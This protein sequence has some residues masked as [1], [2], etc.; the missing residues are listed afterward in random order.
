[1]T[2]MREPVRP[3]FT[4]ALLW[5]G[6]LCTVLLGFSAAANAAVY[7]AESGTLTGGAAVQ[8]D[9]TGYTGT[10]FAGGFTD[11]N[12]GNAQ[13]AWT[14]SAASAGSYTLGL[15][16]ANGTG[17]ARTLSLYVNGTK[18][19][20]TT[21]NATANWDSWSTQND[22]VTLNAG[23]NT[24]AYKY[25]TTDNGNVN[26][27]SLTT[28]AATTP[29]DLVVTSVTWTPAA[30]QTGNAMAFTAIIKNQG[31]TAT[32]AIKHGVNFLVD[33]AQVAWSDNSTS[34]LAPGA[35][36]TL[37][38]N[39]GPAGAT[40][41]ATS[42]A[43]TV[44]AYVDDQNL[45]AESDE[46]NNTLSAPFTVTAPSGG[47]DLV[48]TSLSWSPANPTAPGPVTFTAV[49]K[50]QG[51]VTKAAGTKIGVSFTVDGIQANWSDS[52]TSS[53]AAGASVTL[54]ANSGPAG[55]AS[56]A[57]TGGSHTVQAQVDD[58]N[59]ITESNESNNTSSA[60]LT[61]AAAPA[62]TNG[63][64]RIRNYW[65]SAQYLYEANGK[66]MY[67]TPAANDTSS[68]WALVD[69][70]GHKALWN[71][72]TGN[73]V[74][75]SGI[76]TSA[77]P[78]TTTYADPAPSNV[79]FDLPAAVTSG[80]NNL[81]S[82][83]T[84]AWYANIEGLK[85]FAQAY[86]IDKTWGSAQ[87]AFEQVGSVPVR[88]AAKPDLVVTG[89][90]WS[91]AVPA[92]GQAVTFSATIKN[93]GP[94]ATPAGTINK[95]S[96]AVNGTAVTAVS[97]YS[98]SLAP[99]ASVTLAQDTGSWAMSGAAPTVTATVDSNAAIAETD[100]TNNAFS[101]ILSTT[102]YGASMPY[103]T[104]EAEAGTYAGTLISGGRAW[105][106]LSS[107]ASGRAAVQLRTAGQYVQ[108]T[109]TAAGQ[110]LVVRYSIP[111]SSN[112]AA[113]DAG[114]SLYVNG[115][116]KNDLVLTNKY[117]WLY[118]T[119]S[120]EGGNKR[121][122]N[123]PNATPTNPHRFFDEVAVVLDA[124]YP[125]G[126]VIK[127]VRETS[128]QNFASTASVTVDF[129]ELEPVPAQQAM[130]SNFVS[131]TAYGGV[132]NDGIDDT[133]AMNSAIAA[134]TSSGGAKVGVWIPAGTFNFDTGTVGPGWNGT[135]TRIYL[136]AGVSLR[137]TGI[138]T[139]TLQGAFAG[140][141]AKGGNSNLSDLK[142]SATDI[143][144]DDDN[145]VTGAEGNFSNSTINN[146]WFEHH[147]VGVWTTQ[148]F[149]QAGI[150]TNAKV[151]NCRIRDTWADGLN[152]H[153]GTSNSTASN[154]AIRNTGD[155]GMAMWSEANLDTANVFQNNTVQLPVMANGVAIYGGKNNAVKANLIADTVDNGAGIQFG[156][157][158]A[159]PSITGT[160][161]I[162]GNK[163]LRTGSY[164]HDYNYNIGAIWEYWVGSAGKIASPV[165]TLT[166]N[167]IQDSTYA[168]VFIEEASNGA[169]VTHTGTQ[170]VNTGTYGVEIRSTASGAATFNGTTVTGVPQAHL[171]NNSSNFTV[172]GTIP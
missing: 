154:N 4:W 123:N 60:T 158:F 58:Q 79:L 133:A 115:V 46:S 67:G 38:A 77:D 59:L 70:G 34:S 124:S 149:S 27:D 30:P 52:Y 21:L 1:M 57:S 153:Y 76:A 85:G 141:Y 55:T 106:Q 105:G 166:N 143:L 31:G 150:V 97:N 14:I 122:S 145:G 7:Q 130:P 17:S 157:N 18:V 126:T 23:N 12:K 156:T 80:Y 163:L 15:R 9:H 168:A 116:K 107:E 155:D 49:V 134:V 111:D 148:S 121:W 10:G 5:L 83:A 75:I 109:T 40:W 47:I 129:L 69:Q 84:P 142:I 72:A 8:T 50:N 118:G 20:Q 25:T 56:W 96:F 110:G 88:P 26:L 36:V 147:K 167:L 94:G 54:T 172:T 2:L 16:Y 73:Y 33:G 137:G 151:T 66:V 159:P 140:I 82:V 28:T 78:L 95:I 53:L 74:S 99:G 89:I 117:S 104:Y 48:I 114:L 108:V 62:V 161:E 132:A 24:V 144:R 170:I 39:G 169:S 164:H 19:K 146:V 51:T 131:I 64:Y 35:S 136:P 98:A 125:A 101:T 120:T 139:S 90:T 43:H 6:V 100:E 11:A 92:A 162:S 93:N 171:Q 68:Q 102:A 44:Q 113:Y 65:Q 119:W 32:P 42:G 135:G 3:G 127:L 87:W 160:L 45:I 128:N 152:F 61:V 22:S 41:T 165:I 103:T 71:A 13:V 37:T 112:G 81:Q 91:P 86:A 138:W 63:L 29:A